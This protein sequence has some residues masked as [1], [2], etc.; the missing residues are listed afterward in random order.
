MEKPSSVG[1]RKIVDVQGLEPTYHFEYV[2]IHD[3]RIALIRSYTVWYFIGLPTSIGVFS[4]FIY[5]GLSIGNIQ[6]IALGGIISSLISW[7]TYSISVSVDRD[8][9]GL[10]PRIIFLE[11]L[12]GYDFYREYLRRSPRGETERSFV[13]KL[14]T[15][16]Q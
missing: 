5:F 14:R 6:L 2:A 3:Q 7:V 1:G 10:Y 9:V 4:F 16:E 8:V 13:E 11:I 12:L 15:P